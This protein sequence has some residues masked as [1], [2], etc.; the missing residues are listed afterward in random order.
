MSGYSHIV[1]YDGG[2]LVSEISAGR[3]ISTFS[4]P[5]HN[6]NGDDQWSLGLAPIPPGRTYGEM[7]IL[8]ELP[9]RYLQ[10]AGVPDIL[11]I[12]IR[13][14]GGQQWGVDWVRYTVGH[15]HSG[16]EPLD[17]PIQLAHGVKVISSS[18][19]FGAD[20]AAKLFFSYYEAGDIPSGYA[21]QPIEGYRRDG[22][23]MD[24]S[25]AAAS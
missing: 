1:T 11:T 6:F 20:E 14:P 23:T 21:L 25:N 10:A 16:P 7:L 17:V 12:E 4:V 9:T 18:Q 5:L 2:V 3:D 22:T 13:K 15:S 24:F 8:G 19:V